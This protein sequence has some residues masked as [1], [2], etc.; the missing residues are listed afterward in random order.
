MKLKDFDFRVWDNH[1]KKYIDNIPY[2]IKKYQNENEVFL[3]FSTDLREC[4]FNETFKNEIQIPSDRVEV[5]LWTGLYDKN[6]KKIYEGDIIKYPI[7]NSNNFLYYVVLINPEINIFELFR[8]TMDLEKN[9]L[10]DISKIERL[11]LY[12]FKNINKTE[13]IEII[14][15]THEN[16]E[17]LKN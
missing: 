3:P 5:E 11:S 10:L 2:S 9:K 17:L 12:L 1:N 14:G 6:G 16:P 8:A 7:I 13:E 15:N 4:G